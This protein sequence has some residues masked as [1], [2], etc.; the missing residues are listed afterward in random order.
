MIFY[1]FKPLTLCGHVRLAV[2][3][4]LSGMLLLYTA[5]IAPAQ[6]FVWEFKEEECNVFPTLFF[7]IFVDLFFMVI[8]ALIFQV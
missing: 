6:V 3:L 4:F 1:I 8:I 2:A 7:D 5:I